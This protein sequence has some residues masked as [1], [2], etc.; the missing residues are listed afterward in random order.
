[1]ILLK[2]QDWPTQNGPWAVFENI[3]KHIE[4][5]NHFMAKIEKKTHQNIRKLLAKF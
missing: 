2:K 1:M 5:L 3:A 4:F